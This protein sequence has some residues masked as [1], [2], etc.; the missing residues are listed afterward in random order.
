MQFK[1]ANRKILNI[2]CKSTPPQLH[3]P[4]AVLNLKFYIFN[5]KQ[6]EKKIPAMGLIAGKL[7]T[8]LNF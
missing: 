2:K 4:F 8:M 3:S 5:L 6:I 1:T 7:L